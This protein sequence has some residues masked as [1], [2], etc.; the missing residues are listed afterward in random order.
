MYNINRSQAAKIIGIN[1]NSLNE[2]ISKNNPD[3]FDKDNELID[4]TLASFIEYKD[5]ATRQRIPRPIVEKEKTASEIE[6]I[7]KKKET[8]LRTKVA[9]MKKKEYDA[10]RA[11]LEVKKMKGEL[12]DVEVFQVGIMGIVERMQ[13][14]ILHAPRNYVDDVMSSVLAGKT[15]NVIER[16]M[17]AREEEI[18]KKGH[19][20]LERSFAKLRKSRNL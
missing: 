13:Q 6:N 8:D 1:H 14:E 12:A 10:E 2:Y 11:R 9:T 15:R 5:R 7:Q 3:W 17:T 18:I 16:L 20:T 19:S 4:P